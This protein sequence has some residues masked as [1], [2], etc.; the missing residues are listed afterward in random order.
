MGLVTVRE[1]LD[2]K[3]GEDNNIT[4]TIQS[5]NYDLMANVFLEITK[6]SDG[7]YG[8]YVTSPELVEKKKNGKGLLSYLVIE[9]NKLGQTEF[10]FLESWLEKKL[11]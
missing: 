5:P 2:V 6:K 3:V 1:I 10:Q 9:R 4:Y 7:W 11:S 8:K